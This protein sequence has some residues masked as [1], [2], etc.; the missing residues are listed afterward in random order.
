MLEEAKYVLWAYRAYALIGASQDTER[1][2]YKVLD[3][4]RK[5]DGF[6]VYPINPKYPEIEGLACY[7]SL[8]SL[9][10]IPEVIIVALNPQATEKAMPNL[11]QR[12]ARVIWMPPGCFTQAAVEACQQANVREV[13][14]ICPV[15]ALASI[16]TSS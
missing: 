3:A 4:L 13:H 5:Q 10:E 9:P 1:Y 15:F 16:Q 12:G 8:D 2:G 14:D 7:P 6:R 11:V